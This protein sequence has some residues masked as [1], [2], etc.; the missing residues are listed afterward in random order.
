MSDISEHELK[1]LLN[2]NG[3]KATPQR[4][5]VCNYIL[6]SKEHPSAEKIL[7]D[8]RKKDKTISQATVYKTLTLL[9]KLGLVSELSFDKK[10]SRFDPNQTIHINI[11]CPQCEKISDFESQSVEDFWANIKLEVGG[12]ITGQRIDVYKICKECQE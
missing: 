10:H 11:I 3:L 5:A 6:Q 9:K 4:I 2:K 1:I 7:S 8:L 12:L